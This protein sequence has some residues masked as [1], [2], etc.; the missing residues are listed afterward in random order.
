MAPS[1]LRWSFHSPLRLA[2]VSLTVAGVVVGGLAL[3]AT[4][5][6]GPR[7]PRSTV[8]RLGPTPAPREPVTTMA[9]SP[10]P[11]ESEESE[12]PTPAERVRAKE[13]TEAVAAGSEFVAAW[14]SG[15][16]RAVSAA[17]WKRRMRPLTTHAL[18][19]GLR[20]TDPE[21]LPPGSVRRVRVDSLGAYSAGLTVTLTGGDRVELDLLAQGRDWVV[22]D[23]RPAGA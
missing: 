10:S 23:V 19:T 2:V 4:T 21:R 15:D 7:P 18:F 9:Q 20:A 3:A 16:E 11:D 8:E 1:L 14:T 22:S 5:V 6:S 12:E 13:R 17:R